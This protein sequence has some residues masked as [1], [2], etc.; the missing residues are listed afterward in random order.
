VMGLTLAI[1]KHPIGATAAVA[2]AGAVKPIALLALPFT[3]LLWAGLDSGWWR[4]IRAWVLS[5]VVTVAIFAAGSLLAGVGPGWIAALS[6]PGEVRT[7]LSPLTAIGMLTGMAT[8]AAGITLDDNL[9]VTIARL[10]GT[11]AALGVVAYLA[12]RPQG[13]SPARGAALAFLAVVLLGPVVQPWYLL[14][15]LPLFAATGLRP[16]PFRLSILLIAGF[17]LHAMAESSSTAD[18]LFEFSDGLAIVAAFLVV[19][20]VLLAS[21]RERQLV[22]GSSLSHGLL[23]EDPPEQARARR[24]VFRGRIE[25]RE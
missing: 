15:F 25:H 7:W 6:T 4:R 21:P 2:L 17:S 22:L 10:I 16:L 18:N 12:L 11:V 9:T 23:P 5:V 19:G 1:E 20:L 3:G 13:R 14:W 24:A 8:T